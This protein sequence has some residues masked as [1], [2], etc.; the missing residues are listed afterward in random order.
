MEAAPQPGLLSPIAVV[1]TLVK[2]NKLNSLASHCHTCG[3]KGKIFCDKEKRKKKIRLVTLRY[4][5][6]VN[7]LPGSN[8]FTSGLLTCMKLTV[9]LHPLFQDKTEHVCGLQLVVNH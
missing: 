5:D 7:N 6:K 9:Q 2:E 8:T 1:A 4:M 3:I